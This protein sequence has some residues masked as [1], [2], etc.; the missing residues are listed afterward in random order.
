[1]KYTN[2]TKIKQVN[3]RIKRLGVTLNK[4]ETSEQLIEKLVKKINPKMDL[5]HYNKLKG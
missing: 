3:D 4:N 5:S 1:M 2:T